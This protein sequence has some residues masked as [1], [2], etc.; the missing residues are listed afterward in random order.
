ME[1]RRRRRKEGRKRGNTGVG[2]YTAQTKSHLRGHIETYY[3]RKFLT[4]TC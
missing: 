1:R 3:Y 4:Y 2:G